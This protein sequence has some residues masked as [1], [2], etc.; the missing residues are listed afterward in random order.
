MFSQQYSPVPMEYTKSE[1]EVTTRFLP[2]PL[3]GISQPPPRPRTWRQKQLSGWRVGLT[4]C[5]MA[6]VVVLIVN[7]T[8]TVWA[9]RAST[10][11][12]GFGTLFSGDCQ[13]TKT[14]STWMHL[15]L[16][17]LSTILLSASS[18]AMQICSAPTRTNVMIFL[19][20]STFWLHYL[21]AKMSVCIGRQSPRATE[22][23][24]YW[25]IEPSKSA[26]C[27]LETSESLDNLGVKFCSAA[28]GVSPNVFTPGL[29]VS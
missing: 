20:C 16:N 6:S 15:A 11:R 10:A 12:K 19:L 9:H 28:S 18:Y 24:R 14:L 25:G 21:K 5:T 17:G 7:I 22:M 23:A 1:A 3:P 13:R 2:S 27:R 8:V 4:Y 29:Q 26:S